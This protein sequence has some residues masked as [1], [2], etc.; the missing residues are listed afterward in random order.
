MMPTPNTDLALAF[1]VDVVAKASRIDLCAIHPDLPH[2]H[3]DKIEAATFFPD[4]HEKIRKWIDDRQA[5]RNLYVSPNQA[6]DDARLDWRLS[7]SSVGDVRAIFAD[8]DPAKPT[9]DDDTVEHF[10][11]ERAR[12]DALAKQLS[13]HAKCPPSFIVDSGGGIQPWWLLDKPIAATPENV[14][15]ARG[16]GRTLKARFGGDGVFDVCRLMRVPGTINIPGTYKTAQGRTSALATILIDE[17]S[18]KT[19]TLDQ[20]AE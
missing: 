20:L 7:E 11:K 4:Q 2:K 5:K 13:K 17:S 6:R 19:Y 1:L 14:E 10:K 9:Q 8:I 16:I 12:L 15:L 3:P 18:Q